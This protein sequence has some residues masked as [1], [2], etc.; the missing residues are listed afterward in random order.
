MPVNGSRSA[1]SVSSLLFAPWSM[2]SDD[3]MPNPYDTT[4]S[5]WNTEVSNVS[6]LPASTIPNR[7]KV[8]LPSGCQDLNV[9]VPA[10]TTSSAAKKTTTT[11]S[12]AVANGSSLYAAEPSTTMQFNVPSG[13]RVA[14]ASGTSWTCSNSNTTC[15]L[16]ASI[17]AS[18]SAPQL[19]ASFE[20]SCD[21]TA[22]NVLATLTNFAGN[23]STQTISLTKPAD[24]ELASAGL[25]TGT[26]AGIAAVLVAAAIVV[27]RR[28]ARVQY[29]H[30]LHSRR[31]R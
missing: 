8:A 25:A 26:A 16:G 29:V 5:Y 20:T 21:Y 2:P 9:T 14:S 3:T 4:A 23:T 31:N 27:Y 15:V 7:G 6:S 24:C 30:V 11:A 10:N 12:F 18:G 17:A 19:A 1:T 22:G 28:R 13:V